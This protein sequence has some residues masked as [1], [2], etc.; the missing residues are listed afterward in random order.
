M[1]KDSDKKHKE[2][3]DVV[4]FKGLGY[5]ALPQQIRCVV[6]KKPIG[7]LKVHDLSPYGRPHCVPCYKEAHD[8]VPR[9]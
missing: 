6:C 9:M 3:M 7:L 5:S 1:M 8:E 2:L 4:T